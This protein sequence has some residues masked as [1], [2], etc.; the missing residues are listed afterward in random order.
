M[1]F[2]NAFRIV[3]RGYGLS[4]DI[5]DFKESELYSAINELLSN[6]NFKMNVNWASNVLKSRKHP[7]QEAA[8]W[9]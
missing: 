8:D 7:K 4:L 5:N 1:Q 2:H 3:D 6:S 9:I